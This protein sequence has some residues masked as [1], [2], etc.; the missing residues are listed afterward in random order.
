MKKNLLETL[1]P[2]Y[3]DLMP[4]KTAKK[5]DQA[6][7]YLSLIIKKD[8]FIQFL[9][10]LYYFVQFYDFLRSFID[11]FVRS[12]ILFCTIFYTVLHF[13][14]ILKISDYFIQIVTKKIHWS[15]L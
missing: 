2:L 1:L 11:F 8:L 14:N 4:F 12:F 15:K 3:N 13:C 6:Q 5:R 10:R 7:N 9:Y